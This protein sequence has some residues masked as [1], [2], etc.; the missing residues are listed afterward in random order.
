M[1]NFFFQQ[2]LN[3]KPLDFRSIALPLELE[4]MS[5]L[6]LNFGYP[7]PETCLCYDVDNNLTYASFNDVEF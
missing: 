1:Q 6:K 4:R 2:D 7:N 5:L 3:R